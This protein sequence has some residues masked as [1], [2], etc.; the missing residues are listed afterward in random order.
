MVVAWGRNTFGQT[1]VPFGLSGV[2]AIAAG[3]SHTV[4]LSNGTVVAWGQNLSGQTNVPASLSWV[5]AISAGAYHTLA[6]TPVVPAI[7]IQPLS[8][9]VLKGATVTFTVGALGTNLTAFWLKNGI[10]SPNVTP[11]TL[12]LPNVTRADKGL[13]SVILTNS[14]GSVTSAPALL[15]VVSAQRIMAPARLANGRYQFDFQDEGGGLGADLTRFEIHSTTEFVGAD[16]IWTT[17]DTAGLVIVN[18]AIRFE[19]AGSGN[20][21]RRF[22]RVIEK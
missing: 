19:D 11:L 6:I 21:P 8:Q 2:T 15:S 4:A 17:N 5:T 22:Y 14:S 12:V 9:Q 10:A 13:Y 3:D 1:N 7:V 20:L 18:G 16:T